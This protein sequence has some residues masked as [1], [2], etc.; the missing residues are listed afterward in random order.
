[1][2]GAA[3]VALGLA[4][5]ML[6]RDRRPDRNGN[7][8]L[9]FPLVEQGE[10]LR[11]GTG[12]EV[13]LMIGSA[14]EHTEPLRW[15]DGWTWLSAAQRENASLL[16]GPEARGIAARRGAGYYL[17]GVVVG[18]ADSM[19]VI[20][21]LNDVSGDSVVAQ[22]TS[23]AAHGAATYPQLGLRAMNYLLPVLLEPGRSID[24]SPLADRHPSAIANWLQGEREYRRSHYAL[25][26]EYQ[27]R[28][29]AA[30][31]TMALAAL[32][33]ALAAEW[34]HEYAEAA[35]LVALAL[36]NDSVLPARYVHFAEGLRDYYAGRADSATT[37]L[38][39]AL[40]L[41]PDWS[42][43]LMALGEVRYHLFTDSDS[44]A[45]DA[46]SRARKAD[47][48][49]AP[50][51]FHLAEIAIRN[52]DT[53]QAAALVEAFRRTDPDSLWIEE[54][55]LSLDCLRRGPDK[56]AWRQAAASFPLEAVQSAKVLASRGAHLGC[57]TTGFR[58][59]LAADSAPL[60]ARWGA[61]LGLQG[62]ETARGSLM[63]VEAILD[64]AV[65]A[66]ILA[67]KGLYVV[68]AAAG[69]GMDRQAAAVIAELAGD[70]TRMGTG[71]LWFHG[72]WLAH[73]GDRTGLAAVAAAATHLADSTGM[74][75]ARS[76]AASLSGRLALLSADTT[77][78]IAQL[79]EVA[80][81]GDGA[82]I[83][84]GMQEPFGQERLLLAEVLLAR[85]RPQEAI[86]AADLIDHPR[87]IIYLVFLRES[88]DLRIR[89]AEQLGKAEL[90]A[91]YRAR[92]ARLSE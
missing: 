57:A 40:S 76:T 34:Q 81:A 53:A 66:G 29:V 37:H 51:L 79:L 20:L 62:I 52:S 18:L 43:A 23:A 88:L 59:V 35:D 60:S 25:A 39:Q 46:F 14:L 74:R 31:S 5:W 89:A 72:I 64:S 86:E 6:A 8:V 47:P 12:Q 15:I 55:S 84:W 73:L 13:A 48:E 61:V 80:P 24:P 10:G 70:Y 32:K 75:L 26:L 28:A 54:L 83:E 38:E 67:A 7:R 92:L 90:A 27:R 50:P 45:A 78:A 91:G 41:D 3:A 19:R 21:R 42:D 63:A 11:P 33:G 22:A 85:G 65:A 77:A 17:D 69:H 4:V 16:S 44:A 36:R 56:A 71:R 30:D 58:A 2:I 9:V 68:H 49:F 1:M 87:P 82:Q